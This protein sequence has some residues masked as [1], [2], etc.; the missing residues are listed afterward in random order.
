MEAAGIFL[1][2]SEIENGFFSF[3]AFFAVF[4]KNPSFFKEKNFRDLVK[5]KIRKRRLRTTAFN[6]KFSNSW[7]EFYVVLK[8]S[9]KL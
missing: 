8:F 3:L 1:N 2:Y 4:S 9:G 6:K 7:K 5:L